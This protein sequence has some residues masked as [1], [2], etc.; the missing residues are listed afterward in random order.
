VIAPRLARTLTAAGL[1]VFAASAKTLTPLGKPMSPGGVVT[2]LVPYVMA[3]KII[4]STNFQF[5]GMLRQTNVANLVTVNLTNQP[6]GAALT[7]TLAWSE[8]VTILRTTDL[9]AWAET[10]LVATRTVSLPMGAREFFRVPVQQVSGRLTWDVGDDAAVSGYTVFV[11]TATG[12]YSTNYNAGT[13]T[14]FD[15]P[16]LVAGQ[17]YF[18]AVAAYDASGQIGPLSNEVTYLVPLGQPSTTVKVR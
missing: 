15:V 10:N 8:P 17:N 16:G 14:S 2:N 6:P 4:G 9:Q 5:W 7:A 3:S 13:S 1:F 11:G 12:Q 18:F